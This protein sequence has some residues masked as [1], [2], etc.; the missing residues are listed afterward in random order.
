MVDKTNFIKYKKIAE[1]FYLAAIHE[2]E[3]EIWN[4][5]G[6]LIIH[7]AITYSDA[8]TI[9]YGGVKSQS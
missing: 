6:L 5:A 8:V 1:N 9:K 7:S 4:A 2:I 3:Y